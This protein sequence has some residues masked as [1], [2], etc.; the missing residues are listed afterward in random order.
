MSRKLHEFAV[1]LEFL[2][3]AGL[4]IFFHSVLHYQE[5]AYVIFGIGMLLSL[6]TF[7]VKEEIGKTKEAL[8]VEYQKAHEIPFELARISDPDCRA[9]AQELIAGT[10]RTIT[11]LQHGFIPLDEAEFYLEG[12]RLAEQATGRL[13]AVDPITAGWLTRG[14]LIKYYQSNLRALDRGVRITRIFIL[15][16]EHLDDPEVQEALLTQYRDD[17]DV[18]VA[19]GSELP[20]ARDLEEIVCS[21]DFAVYD[22]RCVTDS[23]GQSGKSF[24]KK[25]SSPDEVAKYLRLFDLIE[26]NA[27]AVVV[28]GDRIVIPTGHC[29]TKPPEEAAELCEGT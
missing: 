25:T 12:A 16:R 9:K 1:W 5:A 15:D 17:I 14:A 10:K 24:G 8:L 28:E 6:A 21:W 4:A 13:K 3:G 19:F 18:R 23:C 29:R 27:Q 7:L 26:H 20:A 11:L 22:E 2:V